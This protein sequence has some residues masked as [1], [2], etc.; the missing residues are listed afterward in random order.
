MLTEPLPIQIFVNTRFQE[1][2]II[3]IIEKWRIESEELQSLVIREF[4]EMGIYSVTPTLEREIK[5]LLVGILVSSPDIIELVRRAERR[6][7]ALRAKNRF[8]NN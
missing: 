5:Q 1:K 8:N 7:E 4:R 6:A 2:E 3:E